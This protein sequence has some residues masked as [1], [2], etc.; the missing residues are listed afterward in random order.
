MLAYAHVYQGQHNYS[1]HPFVPIRI[2]SLVHVK[3]H[4]QRTYAQHCEKGFVIGTL[5]KHYRRQK[6]WMKDTHGTRILGAVWFKH[7]YLTD[8]SVTPE[9]R[10]IAAIGGLA[11]TLRTNIPPQLHDNT[12]DKLQKLQDILQ[13][14]PDGE[15]KV[16]HYKLPRKFQGCI[17][18]TNMHQTIPQCKH[19]MLWL[20]GWQ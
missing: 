12:V 16:H 14:R 3:P 15:S 4:K 8:P 19:P 18:H 9:D 5:F 1:K 11:K 10:I 2:E 13:P 7:K 20:Q 17:H 6:I